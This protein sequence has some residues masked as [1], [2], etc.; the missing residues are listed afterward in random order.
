MNAFAARPAG[1]SCRTL[2]GND[3]LKM[4]T[5]APFSSGELNWLKR[6]F[7]AD[8]KMSNLQNHPERFTT[9]E[10]A[11]PGYLAYNPQKPDIGLRIVKNK[12]GNKKVTKR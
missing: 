12:R 4:T 6:I 3:N 11:E 5:C 10:T 1:Y 8:S 2:S 9:G 7:T